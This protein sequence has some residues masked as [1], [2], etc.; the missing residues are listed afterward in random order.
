M[1]ARNDSADFALFIDSTIAA[2]DFVAGMSAMATAFAA[3]Q[4]TARP[5][6]YT[7]TPESGAATRQVLGAHG[8]TN[9]PGPRS[10]RMTAAQRREVETKVAAAR[11]GFDRGRF[12]GAAA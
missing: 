8:I 5:A 1:A 7:A 3:A 10:S 2:Y 4:R 12:V 9:I 6:P 11:L